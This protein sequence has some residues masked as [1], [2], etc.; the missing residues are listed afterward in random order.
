MMKHRVR[1][2][3]EAI[4]YLLDCTLATVSDMAMKKSRGKHEFERQIAIAQTAIDWMIDF[5]ITPEKGSRAEQV[6]I[7]ANKSV[8]VWS[9]K[10]LS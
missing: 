6:I 1:T 4:L 9:V 10:Y 5:N 8:M 3:E 7:L 2:P